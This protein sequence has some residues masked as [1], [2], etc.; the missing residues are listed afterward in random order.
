MDSLSLYSNISLV[1]G[2][3]A[4]FAYGVRKCLT[5]RKMLYFQ[6]ITAAIGCA[7]VTRLYNVV[8]LICVGEYV[9]G[10]NVG[11]LGP[12]SCFSLL[13]CAEFGALDSLVDKNLKNNKRATIIACIVPACLAVLSAIIIH[14]DSVDKIYRILIFFT[15]LT[16]CAASYFNFKH[17]ILSKEGNEFFEPL[18]LYNTF[19]LLLEVFYV[20]D[21]LFMTYNMEVAYIITNVAV[22]IVAVLILPVLDKGV[23]KWTI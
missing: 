2:F 16:I 14:T 10:F 9:D 22:L 17:L 3:F 12:I 8:S 4:G 18:R 7:A 6:M 11:L 23:G 5:T 15:L 21:L 1:V 20:L 19:A 13:F